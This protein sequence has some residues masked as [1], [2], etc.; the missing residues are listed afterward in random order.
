M[1]LAQL[2][3]FFCCPPCPTKIVNRYAFQPPI[4]TYT[5]K[6]VQENGFEKYKL[7]FLTDNLIAPSHYLKEAE[8]GFINT[9]RGN[10]IAYLLW[11]HK[12]NPRLTILFSHVNGADIGQCATFYLD[13]CQKLNC[14]AVVYDY[15]GYGASSGTPKEKNL[16]A[17]IEAVYRTLTNEYGIC[18]R[19][20]ILYG[21]S[22]G[23]VPTIH[24][25]AK[26]LVAGVI[27]HSGFLSAIRVLYPECNQ[28]GCCDA[29]P[30]IDKIPKVNSPVLVIHGMDDD[31]I[32]FS[33]GI[34]IYERC[35]RAVEPLWIEGA[36]HND[37]ELFAP[38]LDRLKQFVSSEL[39][40]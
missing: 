34:A 11:R 26:Q 37:V 12:R 24:L 28:T 32:E 7:V 19:D 4:P 31:V 16:Y 30:N 13:L 36:G 35:P 40:N 5:L 6:Q 29:F 9:S 10:N 8:Y 17:D 14:N 21:Q 1:S 23:S 20:L 3:R 15:S 25:A 33:H 18:P 22:I 27:I 39:E 38:Y 2:C